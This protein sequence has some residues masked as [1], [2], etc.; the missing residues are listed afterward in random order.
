M[1]YTVARLR[2]SLICVDL[3][4]LGYLGLKI[5][6][7]IIMLTV[8]HLRNSLICVVVSPAYLGLKII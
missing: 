5:I 8:A 1:L 4:S 3:A 7:I 6:Y 2:N